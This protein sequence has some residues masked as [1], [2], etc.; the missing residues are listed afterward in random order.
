MPSVECNTTAAK[1]HV[2]EAERMIQ[3]VKE[4]IRGLLATLPFSHVPKRM[5]IDFVYFV[6]LLLNAFPVKS[7][8]SQTISPRELLMRWRLDYKKHCRVQPGTYCEVHDEPVP[9]NTMA[10][11]AHKAIALGPTGNLQGSIKFYCI[12]TGRVLKRRSFTP[13]LMPDRVIKRVNKIGEQEGHGRTFRFLNRQ[14]QAYEWTDE[15]PKDDDFFQGMLEDEVDATP[16]P[17]ISAELPGV[18]LDKEERE[19][20]TILDEPEP[21]FR[22]MAA[23]ALHN[24]GIDSDETI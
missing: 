7:G 22:D 21:D 14:K 12:D 11:R 3:M 4:R 24:A 18:E 2:S 20:Q 10:W 23:A 17:D 19:F 5:K 9:T 15:V 13:M 8:I 16:Y 1:E 6:I